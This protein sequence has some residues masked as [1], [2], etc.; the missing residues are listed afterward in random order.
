MMGLQGGETISTTH[1]AILT[2]NRSV[3][4]RQTT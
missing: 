3:R 2:Q 1:L 4:D